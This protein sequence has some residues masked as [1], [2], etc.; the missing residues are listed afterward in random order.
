MRL[1]IEKTIEGRS[2]CQE[3]PLIRPNVSIKRESSWTLALREVGVHAYLFDLIRKVGS[4]PIISMTEMIEP[5]MKGRA[6]Q[7]ERAPQTVCEM[8]PA[9]LT[10]GEVRRPRELC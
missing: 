7:L 6:L 4:V 8:I 9:T 2:R 1:S 10:P 5:Q 3:A